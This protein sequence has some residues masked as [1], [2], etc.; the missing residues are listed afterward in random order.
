MDVADEAA[1]ICPT[2]CLTVKREAYL[3]PVGKRTYDHTPIGS[4]IEQGTTA[5]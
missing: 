1:R 2:G 3:T 4:D 5:G